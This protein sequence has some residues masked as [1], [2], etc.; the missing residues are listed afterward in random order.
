MLNEFSKPDSVI[1]VLDC[2]IAFRM[3]IEILE[4]KICCVMKNRPSDDKLYRPIFLQREQFCRR[5]SCSVIG[6][7]VVDEVFAIFQ[8]GCRVYQRIS[9][10]ELHPCLFNPSLKEYRNKD[11][12]RTL[13]AE[14]ESKMGKTGDVKSA[15]YKVHI[16]HCVGFTQWL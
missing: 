16:Q 11:M 12:K 3:E 14:I 2:T 1:P 7:R 13:E 10:Y 5:I 15:T 8:H 9:F 6:W 4:I